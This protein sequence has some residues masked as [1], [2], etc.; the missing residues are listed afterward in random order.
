[1]LL[2][3]YFSFRVILLPLSSYS[4]PFPSRQLTSV[5]LVS[6][7]VSPFRT[8]SRRLHNAGILCRL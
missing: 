6:N 3:F 2:V 1:M 8:T 7:N 5:G 4:F